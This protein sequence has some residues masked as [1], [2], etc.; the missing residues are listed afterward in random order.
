VEILAVPDDERVI[1][2]G[3]DGSEISLPLEE[4]REA[5]LIPEAEAFGRRGR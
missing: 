1:V 2:R 3:E 5:T 4:I